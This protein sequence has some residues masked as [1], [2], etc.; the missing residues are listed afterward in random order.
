MTHVLNGTDLILFKTDLL[1]KLAL[2]QALD[3]SDAV[4]DQLKLP[5]VH[6]E[7]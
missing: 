5:Q 3:L 1:Q 6:E 2:A 7:L 4:V